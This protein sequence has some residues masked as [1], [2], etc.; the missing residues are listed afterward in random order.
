MAGGLVGE[1]GWLV[2]TLLAQLLADAADVVSG[3]GDAVADLGR[4]LID[5]R[6]RL[7]AGLRGRL[8]SLLLSLLL[9]VRG[10]LSH[11]DPP[12]SV[13]L[14]LDSWLPADLLGQQYVQGLSRPAP[15]WKIDHRD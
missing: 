1:L 2:L 12:F 3:R 11:V 4:T 9:Y 8:L 7:V 6:P 10:S 14:G 5:L 15:S 13:V